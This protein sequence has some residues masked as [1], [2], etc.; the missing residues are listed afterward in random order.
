MAPVRQLLRLPNSPLLRSTL[1]GCAG[2]VVYGSWAV[3]ANID[4]GD[5]IGVRSGLVQGTYS[6]VLTFLM[7][8]LTEWLFAKLGAVPLG[9]SVVTGTVCVMLFTTAYGIH[10]LVGT[11]EILM[12]ILPGFIVG[13]AYTAIYVWGLQRGTKPAISGQ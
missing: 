13:S 7:T 2:F 4:H 8:L 1:A 11:P 5:M 6:L 9:P 10:A 3:Y 12:T